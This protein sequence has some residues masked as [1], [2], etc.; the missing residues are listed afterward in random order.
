M[1]LQAITLPPLLTGLLFVM[2]AF[3]SVSLMWFSAWGKGLLAPLPSLV[4]MCSAQYRLIT[5]GLCLWLDA[6]MHCE[7]L[8][9]TCRFYFA[10]D[11]LDVTKMWTMIQAFPCT[12]LP[13]SGQVVLQVP[14]SCLNSPLQF[15]KGILNR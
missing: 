11:T 5:D 15:F 9:C 3:Q 10:L 1:T 12:G 8:L 2:Q 6:R 14:L 4:Q 7:T 13:L